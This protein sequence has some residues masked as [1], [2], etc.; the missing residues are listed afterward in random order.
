M[1]PTAIREQ[2]DDKDCPPKSSNSPSAPAPSTGSTSAGA[3]TMHISSYLDSTGYSRTRTKTG[4]DSVLLKSGERLSLAW[5]HGPAQGIGYAGVGPDAW[6]PAGRGGRFSFLPFIQQEF[7][8]SNQASV[9]MPMGTCLFNAGVTSGAFTY[10]TPQTALQRRAVWNTATNYFHL[11]DFM[12][13][14]SWVFGGY[15][16]PTLAGRV[17]SHRDRNGNVLQYNY[18]SRAG[19]GAGN[20][21]RKITGDLSDATVYFGY[22]SA[23]NEN[24]TAQILEMVIA[25][26]SSP[27]QS[28]RTY[29][30]YDTTLTGLQRVVHAGG[31]ATDYLQQD[32]FR[33]LQSGVTRE[34]DQNGFST[35][36]EYVSN[37]AMILSGTIEPTGRRTYYNYLSGLTTKALLGR[38][39]ARTYY[40]WDSNGIQMVTRDVDARGQNTYYSYRTDNS[41]IYRSRK[42]NGRNTYYHYNADFT[43]SQVTEESIQA[44]TQYRYYPNTTNVRVGIGPRFVAGSLA[45]VTYY[46]YNASHNPTAVVAPLNRRTTMARDAAGHILKEVTPRGTATYFNYAT[47]T[48]LL[49]SRVDAKNQATYFGYDG[50][51][52]QRAVVSPRWRETGSAQAWTTYYAYD[53]RERNRYAQD[54]YGGKSYFDYDSRGD[55]IAQVNARNILTRNR[56]DGLRQRTATFVLQGATVLAK[57]YFTYDIYRNL[58]RSI[59]GLGRTSYFDYDVLDRKVIDVD[60][61]GGQTYFGY[62]VAG[63]RVIARDA[64][65]RNRRAEYDVLSRR[66]SSTDATNAKTYFGYDKGDLLVLQRDALGRRTVHDYDAA[67]RQFRSTDALTRQTYYGYDLNDNVVK[68]RDAAGATMLRTYTPAD[69]LETVTNA[70]NQKTYFGYDAAGNQVRLRNAR[71]FTTQSTYDRLDRLCTVTA[72]DGGKAYFGYDAVGNRTKIRNQRGYT[73][74]AFHDGLNRRVLARDALNGEVYFRY[75]LAGNTTEVLDP[76]RKKTRFGYDKNNRR[77]KIFDALNNKTYFNYDSVGNRTSVVNPRNFTTTFAYEAENRLQTLTNAKSGK[78][79]FGYDAVGNRVNI[80]DA[81]TRRISL[82]YDVLNRVQTSTDPLNGK[83]YFGYDVVGN[84]VK[85]SDQSNR[86][87]VNTYDTLRR[88]VA[89]TNAL[90]QKTYFGYDAVGNMNRVRNPLENSTTLSY[91]SV[92]R[93][94]TIENPLSQRTYFGYDAAGNRVKES[95]GKNQQTVFAYDQLNRLTN[96]QGQQNQRTY[97]LYDAT[98]NLTG[99]IVPGVSRSDVAYDDLGRKRRVLDQRYLSTSTALGYGTQAYGTTPYGGAASSL[100]YQTTVS[101][102]TYDAASNLTVTVDGTGATTSSYDEL[103]R[104]TLR[105]RPKGTTYY[106]YDA[107]SNRTKVQYPVDL[108]RAT[109]TFDALNRMT[110][111]VSPDAKMALYSHS[112]TS[113]VRKLRFGN[114]AVCYY[115]YDSADRV[116][117]I[118]HVTSAGAAILTCDYKRDAAGRITTIS[119]E[120]DLAV[121]YRY[122]TADRLTN[123]IWAKRSTAAQIYAFSYSF[124]NAGNRTKMRR[125]AATGVI[126]ESAYYTYDTANALRKR[127]VA[128]ANTAT[129]YTYDRAGSVIRMIEG[130]NTNTTYYEYGG[131][132]LITA[133]IPPAAQGQPWRFGYDG[134]L[135]RTRI[136]KGSTASYYCW[137]GMNQME[138]RDAAGSVIARYTH[139]QGPVYGVGSVV[140]VMRKTATTTY[141]QYLHMDHQGSVQAVTD[142][143][144]AVTHKYIADG[145]GRQLAPPTGTATPILNELRFQANW[146][147]A[148]I[149]NNFMEISPARVFDCAI[150]RFS[151]ADKLVQSI[152]LLKSGPSGGQK[153]PIYENTHFYPEIT[154]QAAQKEHIT[155]PYV[156]DYLINQ[157]DASGLDGG[158]GS[159]PGLSLGPNGWQYNPPPGGIGGGARPSGGAIIQNALQAQVY[160]M[161]GDGM[162]STLSDGLIHSYKWD[163][164]TMEYYVNPS[165]DELLAKAKDAAKREC[166]KNNKYW[167]KEGTINWG[168]EAAGLLYDGNIV[169][170]LTGHSLRREGK[171][172]VYSTDCCK[173]F[174]ASMDVNF[175]GMDIYKFEAESK[176]AWYKQASE[177]IFYQATELANLWNDA[178]P[179]KIKWQFYHGRGKKF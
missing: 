22:G 175:F 169:S 172:K 170:I 20:I 67:G 126:T 3:N 127:W 35:Y 164:I 77:V 139:G 41:R 28:R 24:A 156:T 71:N 72:S 66:I 76:R 112:A 57:S 109:Y 130:T 141:F 14:E 29:Y 140:E 122:D 56:F 64:L 23:A 37:A 31:C 40:S 39:E 19:G 143:N 118:R 83:T 145:F 88:L 54:V 98:S 176:D 103:N 81:L 42:P 94:Q 105:V 162:D 151:Q 70:L 13:Q 52:N 159:I 73:S 132:G 168:W 148:T 79:Y 120:T 155:N 43:L 84:M 104:E 124:D 149:G 65:N 178:H 158:W 78:T 48:G 116:T 152:R 110:Q 106:G 55:V 174:Y 142:T 68:E 150:G 153:I 160:Y 97:F 119:R 69:E 16:H 60:N 26:K 27:G 113:Q 50:F 146:I 92:G 93:L 107:V 18:T 63:N 134:R 115:A 123:E 99:T 102:F 100:V 12:T 51:T 179:Y 144:Q 34:V 5:N 36:F 10:F 25:S 108:K 90:S 9:Q 157:W 1:F 96:I 173:S 171:Y 161:Y 111:I 138:E 62:D 163:P 129:Y 137:D 53:L 128:P 45:D 166:N 114:N 38:P 85:V 61:A 2:P 4:C 131:H 167:S 147:G 89:T 121:Y 47:A 49:K 135:N 46:E 95:D 11:T 125:E 177:W 86:R 87:T 75:D 154:F 80:S 15:G 44:V 117:S 59:D 165:F 32:T 8:F 6:S 58:K 30:I 17:L 21:L 101:Y 82:T 91:E 74:L 136:V 7:F 33:Y 133:I